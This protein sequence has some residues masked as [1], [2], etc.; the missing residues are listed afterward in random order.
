M[1]Q[2]LQVGRLALELGTRLGAG[3]AG[4]L[5]GH[6]LAV[7]QVLGQVN[8]AHAAAAQLTLNLVAVV[9][10]S[11]GADLFHDVG[12][13]LASVGPL[14]LVQVGLSNSSVYLLPAHP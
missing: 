10:D 4:Q 5:D 11:V 1:V 9:E 7:A 13:F 12:C 6:R 8:R 2:L 3:Q 14:G